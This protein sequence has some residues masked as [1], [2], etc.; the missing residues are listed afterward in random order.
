MAWRATYNDDASLRLIFRHHSTLKFRLQPLPALLDFEH[1]C[2]FGLNEDLFDVRWHK[3]SRQIMSSSTNCGILAAQD[4][5]LYLLEFVVVVSG[6]WWAWGQ[7][8]SL[9]DNQRKNRVQS[10]VTY[11]RQQW[12]K[13]SSAKVMKWSFEETN[14][15]ELKQLV[16]PKEKSQEYSTKSERMTNTHFAQSTIT[17]WKRQMMKRKQAYNRIEEVPRTGNAMAR[18]SDTG[19]YRCYRVPGRRAIVA[20]RGS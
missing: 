7:R 13:T 14:E 12:N 9:K 1:D 15:D 6:F 16:A 8:M 3:V 20:W 19:Q 18:L 11:E 10:A 5:M 2:C 17:W 4:P